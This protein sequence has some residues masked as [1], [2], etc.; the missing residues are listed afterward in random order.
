MSTIIIS[1]TFVIFLRNY[2][3]HHYQKLKYKLE[4][5]KAL[6]EYIKVYDDWLKSSFWEQLVKDPKI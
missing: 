3:Y 6:P 5:D 2:R 1:A 4:R